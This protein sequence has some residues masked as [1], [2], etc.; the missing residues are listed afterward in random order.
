MDSRDSADL[1][2]RG[3]LLRQEVRRRLLRRRR[4]IA[5]V[6][7]AVAAVAALRT[8]APPAPVT[9]TMVVAARDLPAGHV[10]SSDDL[11]RVDI[12]PDLTPRGATEDP[13]GQVLAAPLR[14]G[15]PVTDVRLTGPDLAVGQ[16]T[17]TAAQPVRLTDAGQAALLTPGDRIDLLATDPRAGSASLL[18]ADVAVLAVPQAE[19]AVDPTLPGRLVVLAVPGADVGEIAVASSTSYVTFAWHRG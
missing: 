15:E 7:L 9:T 3:R 12:D 14:R 17:G 8:V 11:A 5:L 10:L 6:L 4:L 18:A 2:R 16:P 13:S 19:Q 1:R